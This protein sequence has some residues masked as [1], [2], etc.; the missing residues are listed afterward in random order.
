MS[1]QLQYY[2]IPI[3]AC[4]CFFAFLFVGK[5]TPLKNISNYFIAGTVLILAVI[6]SE[7]T[8]TAFA[9]P[10]CTYISWQRWAF[11]I[12]AYILRPGIAYVLLLIPLRN[13][14]KAKSV[15][16][17]MAIPLVINAIFLLISPLCGIVYT[18]TGMNSYS[19]GP[20]KYLPFAV[21]VVYLICFVVFLGLSSKSNNVVE[22]KVSILV[23][24][25]VG[26][27]VYVESEF[28]LL[29]SLPTA[30]IIGMIFY[31]VY[32]FIDYYTK[33]SLTGAYQRS[34]FYHDIKRDGFRYFII[35]DINGLKR[36][37]DESG[38]ICGDNA[39]KSFGKSVLSVL[40]PK[41]NFYRIG[42]DEFVILFS[43]VEESNVNQLLKKI[44]SKI[45]TS[46]LPYGISYG[47]AGFN[48]AEDFNT[49]YK[50]A[51]KI[52]YENK[53]RFWEKYRNA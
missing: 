43:C 13:K 18:F 48:K 46:A 9:S 11:S 45:N 50:N 52:L 17:L 14:Q 41:A 32:F 12:I 37:N 23:V 7:M 42:G 25:M 8:E 53:Q 40:P 27:S 30:C 2:I 38:H 39:L 51:D 33:D 31:Y 36:I 28:G 15:S 10:N 21:G 16:Y 4:I 47:F 49:A 1:E 22:R 19:G 29:G 5:T 35:F 26:L 24:I 3:S 44:E 34:K 20:L 6:L